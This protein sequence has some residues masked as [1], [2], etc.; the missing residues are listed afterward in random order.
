VLFDVNNLYVN[1]V[2]FGF[3]PAPLLGELS[4]G[5]VG[6]MHLAGH[7][8]T[9]ECL[10]DDHGA[11]VSE[12]VWSL[13]EEAV[14]RLGPRPTLI[15]WDTDLPSLEVLLAEARRARPTLALNEANRV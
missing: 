9:D 8:R 15:E 10:I 1:A 14:E 2:N 3:D 4:A 12:A 6:E 5:S 13:Y 7:Q 11:R